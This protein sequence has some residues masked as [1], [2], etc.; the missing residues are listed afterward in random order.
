[1]EDNKSILN[2][3]LQS[4]LT[5]DAYSFNAPEI[6]SLIMNNLSN[7]EKEIIQKRFALDGGERKTLEE[8][9]K[10]HNITRERIRQIQASVVKKIKALENVQK[11]ISGFGSIV[12]RII[13][14]YGGIMEESH[15]LDELLAYSENT[16]ESRQAIL[17]II[18]QLLDTELERVKK[19]ELLLPGWKLRL[20]D[21]DLP[22][23]II[24]TLQNIIENEN[25]LL[26]LEELI[27]KYKNH[28][29]F[30]E[31]SNKLSGKLYNQFNNG[32]MG[33]EK[34][35]KII[36]SYLNVSSRIN[37]NILNEWGL[38][39]WPIVTPKRMGDKVYLILK[40]NKR[41]MHFTE[42]TQAIN[43]AGFDKK[44]AYPATIHNELILDDRFVLVGRGIYALNEWGYKS[45]TVADVIIDI[46]KESKTPM[47]KEQIV[48]KVLKKRMVKKST[49]YLALTNK[50]KF[51][52]I[53]DS[54]T[55]V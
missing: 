17:F 42:I 31:H 47:T 8:I 25:R 50:N 48:E 28:A 32:G 4:K 6:L 24:S 10:Q 46:L 54:Y 37:K 1:M 39:S 9:G 19:S 49:I 5:K 51:K 41:P 35:K 26:L 29:L 23:E 38:S 34:I 43:G 12:K 14:E 13:N 22:H 2:K 52:K 11:Q 30:P 18:S 16:P 53:N 44:I 36:Y 33:D 15:L 27:E 55:L 21:L 3:I 45:G 20:L 40:K 7:K